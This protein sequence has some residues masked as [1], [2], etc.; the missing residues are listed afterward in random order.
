MWFLS[1][2]HRIVDIE[3]VVA[4]YGSLEN[5]PKLVLKDAKTAGFA[6]L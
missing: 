2:L 4:S 6:D 5:V 1:K 3:K